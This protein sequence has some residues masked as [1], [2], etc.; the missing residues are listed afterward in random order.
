[1]NAVINQ[2]AYAILQQPLEKV[3]VE[4][5]QQICKSYPFFTPAQ[6]LLAAKLQQNAPNLLVQAQNHIIA[7]PCNITWVNYLLNETP[8]NPTTAGRESVVLSNESKTNAAIAPSEMRAE[9]QS[10]RTDMTDLAAINNIPETEAV[11][12]SFLEEVKNAD[13]FIEINPEPLENSDD[14]QAVDSTNT[15][16]EELPHA[17]AEHIT[18]NKN[19]AVPETALP[20]N[21]M[22]IAEQELVEHLEMQAND[23]NETDQLP[24]TS[25]ENKEPAVE[26]EKLSDIIAAQW[27]SFQEPVETDEELTYEPPHLHTIDYFGSLGITADLTQEP[28]DKLSK[29]L[30]KFTDWLKIVK[31]QHTPDTHAV[32][33]AEVDSIIPGIAQTSNETREIITETMA[34][35]LIKQGKID[36]AVQVYIKLSFLDPDK[37]AYFAKKIEQLKEM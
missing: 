18:E 19:N 15:I 10:E 6:V 8:A 9:E 28:Q 37:S 33:Q 27:A 21:N 35:V 11:T 22:A 7:A 31:N 4:Q 23:A 3:A 32:Q 34:E 14:L 29:Q 20:Q 1:M 25:S 26:N 24:E 2:T 30:L 12:H 5:L 16:Q 36:K 17:L 13:H